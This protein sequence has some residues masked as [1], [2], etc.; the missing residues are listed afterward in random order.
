MISKSSKNGKVNEILKR[1]RSK[2]HKSIEIDDQE[3]KVT[4][5]NDDLEDFE[6]ER[7]EDGGNKNKKNF[8]IIIC[9]A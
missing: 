2:N 5:N 7:D 6:S 4:E 9:V 3:I 1:K 8:T